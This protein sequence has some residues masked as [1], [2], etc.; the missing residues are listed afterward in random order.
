MNVDDGQIYGDWGYAARV[1]GD[2]VGCEFFL[3]VMNIL[4]L[5]MMNS[6]LNVMN[7]VLKM[8][9]FRAE[10]GRIR[11]LLLPRPQRQPVLQDGHTAVRV[12]IL[13]ALYIHAGD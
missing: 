1:D 4:Q 8:T 12:K 7:F 6:L 11:A 9:V 5:K 10:H 3:Q 13:P 2:V